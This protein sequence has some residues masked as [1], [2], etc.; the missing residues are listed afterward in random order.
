MT[1]FISEV[2]QHSLTPHSL[3]RVTSLLSRELRPQGYQPRLVGIAAI[4]SLI[5]EIRAA[6]MISETARSWRNYRVG[7]AVLAYN[8]ENP[9][10][11]SF[12]GANFKPEEGG[13]PN[14]HAEQAALAKARTAGLD[15]AIGIAV[16]GDPSDLDAN[17]SQSPTLRPCR[18]CSEMFTTAPE[19]H[20][21]TLILSGNTDLTTC[22][23]YTAGELAKYYEDP[24]ARGPISEVPSY[25]LADDMDDDWY[26]ANIFIPY[27]LPKMNG[28]YLD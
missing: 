6:N 23:F 27:L 2:P 21:D 24:E 11:G 1:D 4:N 8:F 12:V 9:A 13:G 25:S 16:W 18:R 26:M 14:I 5:W 15:H 20:P 7:A 22:E 3:D 19:V 17:P 28:L 10:M